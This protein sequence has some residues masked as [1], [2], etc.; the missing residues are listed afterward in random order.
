MRPTPETDAIKLTIGGAPGVLQ[1]YDA[2]CRKL[3]RERDKAVELLRDVAAAH[4]GW[5]EINAYLARIDKER[6]S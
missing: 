5:I 6:K 1:D 2:L 3:E 4:D